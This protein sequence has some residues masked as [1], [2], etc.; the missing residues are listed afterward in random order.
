MQN[1]RKAGKKKLGDKLEKLICA[2]KK[3]SVNKIIITGQ[4]KLT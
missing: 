3:V 4:N 2:I 1:G